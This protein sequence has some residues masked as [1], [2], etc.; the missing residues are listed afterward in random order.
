LGLDGILIN[1]KKADF[2]GI[3]TKLEDSK[4]E[5]YEFLSQLINNCKTP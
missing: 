1:R 4:Q 5:A 3:H 2:G